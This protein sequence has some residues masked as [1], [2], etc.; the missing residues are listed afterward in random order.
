M[1]RKHP[2]WSWRQLSCCLYW[3]GGARKRLREEVEKLLRR[4]GAP[5]E[6]VVVVRCPEACGVNVTETMRRAGVDL[7]WPPV[8]IAY[9]VALVGYSP[10]RTRRVRRTAR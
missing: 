10:K 2:E 5:D 7:E 9:Q 3:Q 1:R 6:R 4:L 8:I